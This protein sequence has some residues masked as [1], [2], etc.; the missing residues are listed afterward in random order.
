MSETLEVRAELLKLSRLLGVGEG[1]LDY[2][3]GIPSAEL[4]QL[5]ESATERSSDMLSGRPSAM[6]CSV[7]PDAFNGSRTC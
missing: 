4:R 2:L 6:T 5:R 3:E 1:E 7:A